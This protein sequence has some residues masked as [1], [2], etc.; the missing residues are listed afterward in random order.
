MVSNS[1]FF[2][3]SWLIF[4]SVIAAAGNDGAEGAFYISS[5]GTGLSN[6][7][8]ASIDNVYNLQQ[9][10]VTETG[11]E[12]GKFILEIYTFIKY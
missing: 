9:T 7:A 3:C 1:I 6:I 10:A 12:Y 5:P 8:V 11:R 4:S 2:F